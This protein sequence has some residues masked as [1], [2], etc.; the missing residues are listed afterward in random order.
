MKQVIQNFRSGVLKVDEVPETICR[1]G[2]ILVGN[3][4][5]LISAGTEKMA[6]DLAQKSLVGKAKERPDL[7]R[8]VI[9][10][11]RRDG[12]MAT[13][14][15]VKA[16]LETPIALGYS[17]AGIVR[18]VGKGAEEFRAGDR[19]ACAGM[20]YAS[21][22][23]TVFVPKNLAVKIPD[24]VSF[25]EAA[26]VTLGAIAL[27]GVRTAEAKLGDAV[28]VIGLGLLGQLTVLILKAAGC[29]VIGIDL[30]SSK[31]ELARQHGADAAVLR[32]G[33]VETAV[34]Q[35]TED[36]GVD[37]VIV[38]AAADTNDPIELAGVIAR[39]RA[40]VSMVGAVRMDVP[41][42]VYYEKELQLRLSRSYGPGRYDANYEERGVDYPV[43]YVRWTE[44][45]NMQEFLRL[46]ATK[47]V[48]LD[49]LITH[50]F[51]IGEAER[52]Y[53]IVTGKRR[54]N[55]LGILLTYGEA[56]SA[57][58]V[59]LRAA[60]KAAEVRLGVIGAGNF[61][62]SVLLPRLAKM[63]GV[64]LL[65]LATAT[66][67]TAKA[68]GEQFGFEV[69]STDYRQ[70]LAR[71]DINTVLIATRHNAHAAMTAE[72]L[73]AGKT[74]FVEKPLAID[75]DG[76]S[77]VIAA[78]GQSQGRVMV[79]FNRRFSSLS[80]EL[81]QF[82]AGAGPLAITYRINAGE[83]PKESWI[84]QDE[85][86]GRIVGE[87]CHFVDTLQFL[88]GADIEEVFAYQAS[89]GVDTLSIVLKFSD[90][91]I[92]NINYFATGD[93]GFPKERIEVYGGGRVA[94]LDDFR[95]LEMW[96]EGKR[97]VSKR[98]AQDKG[99]DQELAAFAEAV[100]SGGAM[101]IVWR[102][103]VMTTLA[104]LRIEDA[105]RSGKPEAVIQDLRFEI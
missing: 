49:Q 85:G 40:I 3:V 42:K 104:T 1:S 88:T 71:E 84:Q 31:V 91:S 64:G 22:A 12:L 34:K 30:E 53:E 38:T 5:S 37:A 79:G 55:Y 61:A 77:E 65:G 95:Q 62:K 90:G 56:R 9:G 73:R 48:R 52:A 105:L 89:S 25:D 93:R 10:K 28:A 46:L 27:Q 26:F 16:K 14:Q 24:G 39:D 58:I 92:G 11:L 4:S 15:T 83:I 8:Q 72:A 70:L 43:G 67:R 94:V 19:V 18:E 86:G 2:G 87:V 82:L 100:R 80:A 47:A 76:L 66:G 96:S 44:R 97:K 102:S 29:R 33:D 101:P 60:R 59:E 78:V 75:E 36:F 57:K 50:R 17:C 103:L 13:L 41:R 54:E 7:V 6:I 68:V 21:H 74:V 63:N 32:G 51:P 23:E 20:N 81:K 98:L 69:C 35:F 45:R 99:F